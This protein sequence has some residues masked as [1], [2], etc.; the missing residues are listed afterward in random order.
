[1]RTAPPPPLPPPRP[2]SIS[3][4]ATSGVARHDSSSSILPLINFDDVNDSNDEED[5]DDFIE[6][7]EKNSSVHQMSQNVSMGG[8]PEG[9]KNLTNSV[10]S[11]KQ[12]ILHDQGREMDS[13]RSMDHRV[14][15]LK[16]SLENSF[17]RLSLLVEET[18]SLKTSSKR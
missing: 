9:V 6:R 11:L 16:E 8:L 10:K 17:H 5:R 2:N 18:K 15:R 13:L 14:Q 3:V 7:Y 12:I 1:M 4:P